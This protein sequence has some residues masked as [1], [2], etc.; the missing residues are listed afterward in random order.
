MSFLIKELEIGFFR[1]MAAL[2]KL[3]AHITG[4]K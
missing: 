2:H 1:F 3:P 4:S